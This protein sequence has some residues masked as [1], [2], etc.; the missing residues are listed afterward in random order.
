MNTFLRC[1][2]LILLMAACQQK[3]PEVI[4]AQEE[5]S[6]ATNL[7]A[8]G[9]EKLSS[10]DFFKGELKNLQPV[11]GVIGYTLNS[12]LFSDYAFKKRFVKIPKGKNV[13]Y[14]ATEV[15][16]F[17]EGTVLIK[18]FYYPSDFRKPEEQKRILETRLLILE[19]GNWKALPYIWNDEQTEAY[20]EVAGKNIE[21][22]WIHFNGEKRKVN[23]SV[24]NVNQCKGC[25]LHGDQLSP[26]GPSARQL[27][28]N[29]VSTNQ[30]LAW[31][32]ANVLDGLPDLK[33]IP[34]L[35]S[36][37]NKNESI[38]QRA[39]AWLEIN[40]AHCHRADGPAKT[41]GLHLL[42]SLNASA[43]LGIGKAPVAAGKGSGGRL[44]GIVPGKPEESIL[45]YRIE[46]T[47][48]GIMMPELGRKLV[49]EEGVEL[50][51][52][53]ISEMK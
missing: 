2:A 15:L 28:S 38:D 37:E 12:P 53:W 20:L 39:R 22:E 47:H 49:H 9:P 29:D 17:P 14:H 34:L 21:V 43:Q 1:S 8:L 24:P 26:I 16:N 41:S 42:A 45:Q 10:Y 30:L 35:A 33:S 48:P 25:H 23:Y 51:R 19:N 52:Q 50:V 46:S 7:S 13:S 5:V 3:K 32:R 18:N 27:N 6:L 4:V 31:Q 40:C 11:E 36:Y 44:F